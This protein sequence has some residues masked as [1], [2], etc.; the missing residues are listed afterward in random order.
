MLLFMIVMPRR[1][2]KKMEP[3]RSPAHRKRF[4]RFLKSKKKEKD[5]QK[6]GTFQESSSNSLHDNPIAPVV[7]SSAIGARKLLRHFQL[8]EHG[9]RFRQPLP[10]R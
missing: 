1:L 5:H 4:Q 2:K 10:C 6:L 3:A 8:L 9:L 7:N